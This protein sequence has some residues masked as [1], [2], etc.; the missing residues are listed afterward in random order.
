[1]VRR[2]YPTNKHKDLCDFRLTIVFIFFV[3]MFGGIIAR[4]FQIQVLSHQ[5]YESMAHSQYWNY[6]TV[7]AIRGDILSREKHVLAGTQVHYLMFGEPQRIK[8]PYQL[9]HDLAQILAEIKKDKIEDGVEEDAEELF[10]QYKDRIHKA[11]TQDLFWV[12]L[13]KN[14]TPPEMELIQSKGFEGVG[15]EEQPVRYYPEGKL[16]SHVLGF[17]A[18]NERGDKIGYF[19]IEGRLNEDLRGKEGR[20]IE[21]IDAAGTPILIGSY[22]QVSPVEGRDVILTIDRSI[23]YMLE[24]KIEE[25]VKKY[26]AVSGSVIVMDPYTGEVLGMANYPSYYP[27]DFSSVEEISE[28]FP[29]RKNIEKKNLS[30][31]QTYEP[32]SVIKP[33]TISCAIDLGLI[34]PQTTFEDNGPA[35]YSDYYIDNWDGVHHGTQ[36]II[37]LLQKSNNVGAAWVGHLIGGRKLHKYFTDFGLGENT[38]IELEG[39]DTGII[40]SVDE[41]TDID[42]ATAA[43]GQGISATPLQVLNAFNAIAN[44]GFLIEPKIISAIIDRGEEISIPTRSLQRVISQE[45]SETMVDLLEKAAEGGEASYFVMKDYRIAGKTGTGQIP[46]EGKYSPDRTNGTFAGF[47]AV[48][49]KFSMIVKLE[50]PHT[51]Y[52]ASE[53]A[54]PL[55]MDIAEELI[56]YYGLP[57]DKIP[58]QT[59]L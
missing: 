56:K 23:Q 51:S 57:P 7:P 38:G 16:A 10:L 36:N 5:K 1:M 17:V 3:L 55:W 40:R 25:G 48:S 19:G 43:F 42:I 13:E 24:K 34:N 47:M 45:T 37:Q 52:Y 18:S 8:D 49:K 50:E 46:E 44:G 20:I 22:N 59:P 21:E 41:W 26:E 58:E 31:S 11:I 28:E 35:R 32:G 2:K 12:P 53:T 29:H 54:V 27:D 4:L 39:E 33:L 30:I 14:L 9:A 15:F 6:R